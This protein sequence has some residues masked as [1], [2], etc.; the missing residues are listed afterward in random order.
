[1]YDL[2]SLEDDYSVHQLQK[3]AILISFTLLLKEINQYLDWLKHLTASHF[4]LSL[5]RLA[6][7][8]T[9]SRDSEQWLNCNMEHWEQ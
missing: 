4:A 7:A 9:N 2:H 3:T 6:P 1:M 5:L 8:C